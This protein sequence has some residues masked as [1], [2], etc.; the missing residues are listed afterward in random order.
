MP[1]PPT[2]PPELAVL[3]HRADHLVVTD[4]DGE[5][6][7]YDQDRQQAHLLNPTAALVLGR[8]DGLTRLADLVDELA[9]SYRVDPHVVGADVQAALADFATRSLVGAG[10]RPPSAESRPAGR[11]TGPD[12][13]PGADPWVWESP[14]LDALGTRVRMRTDDPVAGRYLEQVF[15]SLAARR[16]AAAGDVRPVSTFDLV[17]VAEPEPAVDLRLDGELVTS[18]TDLDSAVTFLHWRLNQL[19]IDG[20]TNRVLLHA[21]GVRRP[22]GVAVFP[23]ESNSG[24]STLAAGLVRAGFGYVTD[25][26]VALDLVNGR[27]VAFPKPISLDPGSW[28]LFSGHEPAIAGAPGAFFRHEWHLDPRSLSASALDAVDAEQF[29]SL[30]AFPRYVAG[31]VTATEPMR[32]A[33][34]LLGLLR[35]AFNLATVGAPGVAAL[36]AVAR[37]ATVVSITVGDLDRAIELIGRLD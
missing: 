9:T 6:V 23:A 12:H 17:R 25:E 19:T 30:V 28:P 32:P 5:Q 1:G 22:D 7:V 10:A 2:L 27:V 8:C 31:A 24:K 18:S 36:E 14:E 4:F 20:A 33:V 29:V 21:S 35:N 15:G 34:A 11:A 16:P 26:A 13:D 37:Q 3:P